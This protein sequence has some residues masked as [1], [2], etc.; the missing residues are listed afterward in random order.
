MKKT[1]IVFDLGGVLI[2][3]E[4][5]HLY[6]KMFDGNTAEMEYFLSE[7]C[8]L[9]WNAE[10]DAGRPFAEAVAAKIQEYPA[11]EPYIAAYDARWEEMVVGPIAGTVT[12]LAELKTAGYPVYALSNWSAETFPIVS[13]RFEF[14]NWFEDIVLSG[15]VKAVKPDARIYEIMLE[16]IGKR[17]SDCLF[18]D[19]S[20]PNIEAA[21]ALGWQSIHFQ[22]SEQ[23]R[24]KLKDVI[25]D[26]AP[27]PNL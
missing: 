3:W 26:D 22:S 6:R 15:E 18:I 14:L 21:R 9:T 10:L 16:R 7:I 5:R 12:L 19:D 23:L 11:Y 24:S 17:P 27:A 8:P 25:G 1:A 4:S 13:R 2:D 20:L